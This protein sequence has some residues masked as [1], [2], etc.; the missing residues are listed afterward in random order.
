MRKILITLII[1]LLSAPASALA[2]GERILVTNTR[3]GTLSDPHLSIPRGPSG[4]LAN[5]PADNDSGIG[6][7]SIITFTPTTSG[8]HYLSAGADRDWTGSYTLYVT[9][10]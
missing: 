3:D 5:A 2:A 4:P 6:L 9:E 8:V 7:N 1:F 10:I